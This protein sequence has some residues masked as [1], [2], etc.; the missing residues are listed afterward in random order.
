[1][2]TTVALLVALVVAGALAL[3]VHRVDQHHV[4]KQT[5]CE[6]RLNVV[7]A[8]GAGGLPD[9]VLLERLLEHRDA[10]IADAAF[11]DQARRL[12]VNTQQIDSARALLV[13]VNNRHALT[14]DEQ[15]A[16]S[17][18]VDLGDAQR[19]WVNGDE[20]VAR[21]LHASAVTVATALQA[22]WPEWSLPYRILEEASHVEWVTRD[23]A[24]TVDW[25]QRERSA[26]GR[27]LNG[28]FARNFSD[29]QPPTYVFVI[30]V[31]GMLGFCACVTGL[32]ELREMKGM[33]TSSIASAMP[34]YVELK[35]TLHVLPNTNAVVGPY[36]KTPGVWYE[37]E[38]TTSFRGWRS[39][40]QHSAP[41]FVL[42]DASGDAI[43][44]ANGITARTS[45]ITSILGSSGSVTRRKRIYEKLLI[46]GDSVYVL[47]ELRI[48]S[49]PD[50]SNNR[51][52]RVAE[53]G[54]RLLVSTFSEEQLQQMQCWFLWSG[55]AVLA[56]SVL[57]LAWSYVQR[58]QVMTAPGM[59]P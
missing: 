11:I 16:Q 18:W 51:H 53:N 30:T 21:P 52:L 25:Y 50:G 5:A 2:S 42:R 41:S 10:C 38:T 49:A 43:V 58:Y 32:I 54:R 14:R 7:F 34:G 35:G 26:R 40:Y 19:T 56:A 17:A 6:K 8:N 37:V 44:D 13:D 1:M 24:P 55:A 12:M 46:E 48:T 47:G 15:S 3:S 59:L 28:A 31:I 36:S 4:P 33:H 20:R 23:S 57:I 22:R 27:V 29:W 39:V 45:H 9:S